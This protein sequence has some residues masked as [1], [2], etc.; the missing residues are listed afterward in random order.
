MLYCR[1]F[2]LVHHF[3]LL[4]LAVLWLVGLLFQ[5]VFYSKNFFTHNFSCGPQ[6]GWAFSQVFCATILRKKTNKNMFTTNLWCGNLAACIATR[7]GET[8]MEK[9]CPLLR[10]YTCVFVLCSFSCFPCSRLFLLLF[11]FQIPSNMRF[12]PKTS[13]HNFS[14]IWPLVWL[15]FPKSCVKDFWEKTVSNKSVVR[16]SAVCIVAGN[17]GTVIVM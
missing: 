3:S 14:C 13:S 6:F 1:T 9:F 2:D 7:D 8:K 11:F 15:F 17:G 4:L 10:L 16:E 12:I 5:C